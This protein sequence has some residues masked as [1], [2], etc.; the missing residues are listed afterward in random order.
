MHIIEN[1][2]ERRTRA[3]LFHRFAMENCTLAAMIKSHKEVYNQ[4]I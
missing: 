3:N 1:N 4:L 2:E